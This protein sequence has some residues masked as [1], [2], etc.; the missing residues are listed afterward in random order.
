MFFWEQYVR[1][2]AR[3][4]PLPKHMYLWI[5]VYT[6]TMYP[7]SLRIYRHLKRSISMCLHTK[8]NGLINGYINRYIQTHTHICVYV[9]VHTHT[10]THTYQSANPLPHSATRGTNKQINHAEG[11]SRLPRSIFLARRR[12]TLIWRGLERFEG[13]CPLRYLYCSVL[14]A[15]FTIHWSA[16]RFHVGFWYG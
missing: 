3:V 6:H 13:A 7:L 8:I 16:D 11:S 4:S 15:L 2:R 9:Y 10:R 12:K 5:Y 1:V 14:T